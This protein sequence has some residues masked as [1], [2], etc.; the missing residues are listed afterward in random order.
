MPNFQ[1]KWQLNCHFIA[2]QVTYFSKEIYMK[3]SIIRKLFLTTIIFAVF[4]TNAANLPT[5]STDR[6]NLVR[7]KLAK[8]ET[9]FDGKIGI[10]AINTNNNEVIAYRDNEKFPVQSTLKMMG[11]AALLK[12]SESNPALLQENIHYTKKDLVYWHPVSGKYLNQGMTL[13]AMGEA[14]VT[15]TD[16]PAMNLI[17]KRFGGPKFVTN[18]ANSIGNKSFNIEHYEGELNS[19]PKD[20]RD[21]ATPKDMAIS[22]QKIMLGNVLSEPNK[23]L[24]VTWMRNSVTSGKRIRAGTPPLWAVADKTGSGDYGVANDIGIAW[25]PGCKPVVLAIYTAQNKKDAKRRE[26]ILASATGI[27]FDEFA[28]HSSCFKELY[29]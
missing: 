28:K 3:S 9:S 18:F 13:E 4:F 5:V 17:M 12:Q 10:Y 15:Y 7:E 26:E 11:V 16:N 19:N 22:V 27:I 25:A 14:S 21:T 8:L 23:K 29:E 20:E 24:L 6:P 1:Q 2:E